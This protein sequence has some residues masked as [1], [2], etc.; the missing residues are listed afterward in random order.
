MLHD[1]FLRLY[2]RVFHMTHRNSWSTIQKLGLLSTA[3]LLEAWQ[4]PAEERALILRAPRPDSIL[5]EDPELGQAVIRD[6]KP[7]HIPSLAATLIDLSVSEWLAELN[8]R[9]FFFV[10]EERL[11][12][13]LSARSYRSTPSL[14]L[15]LDTRSLLEAHGDNVELCAINSGFARPHSKAARGAATFQTIEEYSHPW[16]ETARVRPKWDVAELCVRGAVPDV[17]VHVISASVIHGGA[18]VERLR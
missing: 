11:R 16:R 10:Q 2:P 17:M 6:Q 1:D 9:V 3:A 14:V 13:L 15:E 7:L 18:V 12:G 4:V 5:L 8:S